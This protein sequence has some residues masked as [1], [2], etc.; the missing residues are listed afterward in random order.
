MWFTNDTRLGLPPLLALETL[1]P[2]DVDDEAAVRRRRRTN[3]H[4]ARMTSRARFTRMMAI[5]KGDV[6]DEEESV[7]AAADAWL[8]LLVLPL[9]DDGDEDDDDDDE[10][11][12]DE[13]VD[14]D[15]AGTKLMVVLG[16]EMAVTRASKTG[17]LLPT[18]RRFEPPLP[19]GAIDDTTHQAWD[20][21]EN[22][23]RAAVSDE[24]FADDDSVVKLAPLD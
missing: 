15:E 11:D 22:V 7:E 18:S 13:D 9:V 21:A 17:S 3:R 6:D 2:A 16:V 19:L 8:L 24:L 1:F 5:H 14:A 12:E 20:D 4:T 10:D 23:T